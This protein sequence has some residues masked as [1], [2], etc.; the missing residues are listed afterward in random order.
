MI[1]KSEVDFETL[2]CFQTSLPLASSPLWMFDGD[3]CTTAQAPLAAPG[4]LISSK[5]RFANKSKALP[6]CPQR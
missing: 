3:I 1:I 2:C 6:V 5:L 4:E